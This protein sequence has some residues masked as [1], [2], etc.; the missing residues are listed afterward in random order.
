MEEIV[1]SIDLMGGD[2]KITA[3]IEGM[4]LFAK[5]SKNK[6]KFLAFGTKESKEHITEDLKPFTTFFESESYIKSDDDPVLAMRRGKNSSMFM[7]IDAVAKGQANASISAGN[8]GALMAISKLCFRTLEGIDRPAIA[9]IIPTQKSFTLLLDMGAN[10]ECEAKNLYEF[11][12]MGQAFVSSVCGIEKPSVGILNIGTEENKGR[13]L[14]KN[15]LALF[16]EKFSPD[17]LKNFVEGND[18]MTGNCNVIVTDGFC[19][20]IA[21]KTMEGAGKLMGGQLRSSIS[22]SILG[23]IGYLIAKSCFAK[24]KERFDPNNY[25]GAMFL[26]LNGISIKSHGS[27]N[28][29]GFKNAIKVAYNLA[30]NDIISKIKQHIGK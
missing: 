3:P 15:A 29:K 21:L 8:T 2:N 14:E 28:P 19:G 12:F 6:V 24:F 9:T 23:K 11:A 18:I 22:S 25:N 17:I 1:L 16:K 27:A 5:E 13:I 4:R 20:N 30:E 10:T 7:A 26:G